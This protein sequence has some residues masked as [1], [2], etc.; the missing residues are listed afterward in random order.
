MLACR[1]RYGDSLEEYFYEKIVLLNRCNISGKN[2][3]DCILFGIEDR[4][5]K[6]SAEAAQFT[7]PDKLLVYLRN[8]KNAKRPD[9]INTT[10]QASNSDNKR[11]VNNFHKNNFGSK[12]VKPKCYNCGE[13]GHPYFKCKLGGPYFSTFEISPG[14]FVI[15]LY[16]S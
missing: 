1:A 11:N 12:Y 9:K 16:T 5:V 7:E 4:S 3:I 15:R 2:A 13:E 6:T 10:L 8:V 14:H